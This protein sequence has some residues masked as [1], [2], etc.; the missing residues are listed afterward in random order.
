MINEPDS[1]WAKVISAK[2][3][4]GA[5]RIESLKSKH[6]T[7]NLWQGILKVNEVLTSNVMVAIGNGKKTLFWMDNWLFNEPIFNL[8]LR[9][10]E[11]VDKYKLMKGYWDS[12]M[13]WKWEALHDLVPE[14]VMNK[15]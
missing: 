8:A 14:Q 12:N 15:L 11:L 10:I 2:Y 7:F 1:L 4:H 13:G 6:N 3:V 5:P 9:N